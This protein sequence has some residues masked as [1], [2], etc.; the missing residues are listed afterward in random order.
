MEI[1]PSETNAM[2][3]DQVVDLMQMD[4]TVYPENAMDEPASPIGSLTQ[5]DQSAEMSMN[6][7]VQTAQDEINLMEEQAEEIEQASL[8]SMNELTKD[9]EDEEM[10]DDV[11]DSEEE[12][13]TIPAKSGSDSSGSDK[14]ESAS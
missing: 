1:T 13:E 4:P 3:E 9:E 5:L 14:S 7:E 11:S 6:N 8:Y 12:S 10:K 2:L